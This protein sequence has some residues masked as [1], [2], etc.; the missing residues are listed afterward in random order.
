MWNKLMGKV[1]SIIHVDEY[2]CKAATFFIIISSAVII[3]D[4][5]VEGAISKWSVGDVLV[6]AAALTFEVYFIIVAVRRRSK[7]FTK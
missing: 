6:I 2:R 4:K 3:I 1:W 5:L 7:W